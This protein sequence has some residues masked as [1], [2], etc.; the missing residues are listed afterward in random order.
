MY[1]CN[2]VRKDAKRNWNRRNNSLVCDIFVIDSISIGGEPGPLAPP[3]YAYASTPPLLF[4]TEPTLQKSNFSQYQGTGFVLHF[5]FLVST[6]SLLPLNCCSQSSR[7]IVLSHHFLMTCD[8]FSELCLHECLFS[9]EALNH[10]HKIKPLLRNSTIAVA[11]NQN[12][13]PSFAK[14]SLLYDSILLLKTL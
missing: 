11:I 2:V 10:W 9:L 7:A 4:A 12:L 6:A 8:S 5:C 1:A 14:F 13:L 3:G